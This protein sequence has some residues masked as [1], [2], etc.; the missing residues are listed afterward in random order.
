M[1][2]L[3]GRYLMV[4]A[5]FLILSLS[6]SSGSQVRIDFLNLALPIRVRH[7]IE[8]ATCIATAIPFS[9]IGWLAGT[10][11]LVSFQRSEI[12][13]GQ[14][15]WPVWLTTALV[16]FGT[17]LLVLRLTMDAVGH[18]G[19]VAGAKNAPPLQKAERGH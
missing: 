3:V 1:Q 18:L 5:Y 2:D 10:R 14:I 15:P 19:G 12:L 16:A 17:A 8:A 4:A 9:L 11:S 7:P 13:P 6:Y